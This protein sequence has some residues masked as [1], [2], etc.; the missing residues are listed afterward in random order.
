MACS[1]FL[2]DAPLIF[3]KVH[4][5]VNVRTMVDIPFVDK[6]KL[7]VKFARSSGPGGQHVNKTESKV[8][9]RININEL[10]LPPEVHERL[11][12]LHGGKINKDNELVVTSDSTR[13]RHRNYDE[14]LQKLA[15]I[16][17]EAATAPKERN[18]NSKTKGRFNANRL[19]EK[20]I[21]SR[22][23]DMRRMDF[24]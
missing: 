1:R 5:Y 21:M 18:M 2:R 8:D 19:D 11:F 16:M 12:E 10:N 14:C 24:D 22:K 9:L 4:K 15:D 6:T 3:W 23:K 17:V 20:K 7:M 13:T